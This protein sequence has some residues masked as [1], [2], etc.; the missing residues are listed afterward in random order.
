LER[1]NRDRGFARCFEGVDSLDTVMEIVR[2]SGY[3]FTP[4]DLKYAV[5]SLSNMS[6]EELAHVSG[7]VAV[8][9]WGNN[10]LNMFELVKW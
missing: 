6:E 1:I 3:N 4:E 8:P 5:V 7:G 10:I 2:L 9:M